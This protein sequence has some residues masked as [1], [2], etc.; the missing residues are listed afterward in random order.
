[1]R[2]ADIRGHGHVKELLRRTVVSGRVP[3]ALLFHGP[4]GVGK[5]SLALAFLS[6][7]VCRDPRPDD[8]CGE[9]VPCR[10]VED[11]SFVDLATL[12]PEKGTLKIDVVR[13]ALPRLQ[14]EPLV[15]PWK[16]VI[17]DDAHTLTIEAANAALKTLEEPPRNS[18]FVLVTPSPDTLPRTV[19]SRCLAVPFGPLKT[20]EVA[21]LLVSRGVSD[22]EAR[23][24][25]ARSR[26]SPGA[27]LHL[28]DSPV[29]KERSA[30]VGQFLALAGASPEA[31]L[32]FSDGVAGGRDEVEDYMDLLESVLRDL[33]LAA[34]GAPDSALGNA[35]LA[36]PLRTAAERIG[37]DAAARLVE[38][39]LAWEGSRRYVPQAR[40]AVDRIGLAARR[41]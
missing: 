41:G 38:A 20:D 4:E 24:A 7:L 8:A 5:R 6:W 10:Q 36:M 19:V 32:A 14:F 9:C 23:A 22:D 2:L 21:D 26:G 27:A 40:W 16:C 25:A 3:H 15:G 30:F 17:V 34:S 31:C 28:L 39:W 29:L 11:G 1:M 18:L 35:D 12:A 13:E 33:L 37:P